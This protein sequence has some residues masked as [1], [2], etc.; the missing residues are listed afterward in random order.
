[1]NFEGE[2]KSLR[3]ALRGTDRVGLEIHLE[4]KIE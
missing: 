1:M 2:I 4:A 3:K